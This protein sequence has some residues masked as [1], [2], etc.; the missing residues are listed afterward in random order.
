MRAAA[1]NDRVADADIERSQA[2]S[3]ADIA[4][5]HRIILKRSGG[6]FVGPCPLCGGTDRFAINSKKQVFN[7]RG[8]N[9]KGRG[10]IAFIQWLD[11]VG[12]RDA[13]EILIGQQKPRSN[14]LRQGRELNLPRPA[15]PA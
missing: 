15:S 7:C 14:T 12:F 6:E 1:T 11:G 3:L 5:E 13:V 2:V 4:I 8:C 10:A 9:G